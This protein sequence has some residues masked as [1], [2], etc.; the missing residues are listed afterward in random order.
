MQCKISIQRQIY[1]CGI[2][3]HASPVAHGIMEYLIDINHEACAKLTLTGILKITDNFVITGIARDSSM[4][5]STT[6][7]GKIGQD[8]TCVGTQYAD[9]YGT[10][11][12]VVVIGGVRVKLQE[13]LPRLN[14]NTGRINLRS[15]I[16]C[17]ISDTGCVDIE[18]GNSYWNRL[19]PDQCQFSSYDMLYDGPRNRI[20]S[21]DDDDSRIIYT[22]T[23]GDTRFALAQRGVISICGYT[24][25]R[26]EHP[27]LFIFEGR[28]SH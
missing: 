5:S 14:I 7:A 2:H 1:H 16:S 10:W 9:P 3:S 4:T 13:Y 26:M 12:N 15:G 20:S 23:K 11:D 24:I 17:D 6:L 25:V 28:K 21:E 19:P 22:V 27:R 8:G 18:G